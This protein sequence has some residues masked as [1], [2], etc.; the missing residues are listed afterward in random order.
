LSCRIDFEVPRLS[1][2]IQVYDDFLIW[3]PQ[4]FEGDVCAMSPWA[5]VVRVQC[6]F[7]SIAVDVRHFD[8]NIED[9]K[10]R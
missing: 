1:W 6:D 4:L 10:S 9:L 5:A 7:G 8:A 2:L 3:Q